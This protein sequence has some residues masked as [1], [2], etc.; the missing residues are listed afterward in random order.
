M[1]KTNVAVIAILLIS[2]AATA[3]VATGPQPFGSFGGGPFDSVNLGSLN[4]NFS[5]PITQ[6]AGRGAPFYYVLSYNSSIW[7]P[8]SVSGTMAWQPTSTSYGWQ[9]QTNAAM[10]GYLS[11][12]AVH[13]RCS[14]SG[15]YWSFSNFVYHDPV[16]GTHLFVGADS[17]LDCDGGSYA[18]S[19]ITEDGTGLT[20]NL[21]TGTSLDG[22]IT[23]RDGSIVN[24]PNVS[25]PSYVDK[26][27]NEITTDGTNFY[28][29]LGA[30][31]LTISGAAPN[32][33]SYTFP[34]SSGGNS[35]VTADYTSFTI[36]TNFGCAGVAEYS[37]AGN[38]LSGMTLPDGTQYQ[39]TYEQTPGQDA[40]HTT[41][42]IAS[43]TLPGTGKIMY[44]YSGGNNGINCSD[45][46]SAGL[47]RALQS[48]PPAT[49]GI[50]T[51]TRSPN[52]AN[53]NTTIT[54]PAGNQS[55]VQFAILNS[56]FYEVQRQVY[57]GSI[58]P[59]S[60]LLGTTHC[61]NGS[62]DYTISAPVT[63]LDVW[64]QP[65]GAPSAKDSE[66]AYNAFGLPTSI[67]E[68]DFDGS[69]NL[70]IAYINYASP[71]NGIVSEPSD[72]TVTDGAGNWV[73]RTV[74]VY[75]ETA[76]TAT[77]GAP[78]H[79]YANYGS[80]FTQRG[81]LTTAKQWVS[82]STYI[83]IASTYDDLGNLRSST[84]A[85]GH[86]TTFDYTDSY[87]DG[88]NHNSQAF[89]TTM[90]Y[91][92]TASGG[93]PTQSHVVKNKYYWPS[94][95]IY[96][97]TDQNNQVTTYT[98]DN[99]WRPSMISYPDG[100]QTSFTHSIFGG[101]MLTET[102]SKIDGTNSTDV[103]HLMDGFGRPSRAAQFN[104]GEVGGGYDQVD[105]CYNSSGQVS[106]V[107]DGYQGPGNAQKICSGAGD[108]FTY[109]ALGRT[110]SVT[111]SD[112]TSVLTT[113]AGR[114]MQVQDE[115]NGSGTHVTHIY[116]Q[117][118]LG[119]TATVC[120]VA[121]T[122]F[123]TGG[124]GACGLDISANPIGVTTSYNYDPLGN[125]T[126]VS[127]GALIARQMSYDGLG[128]LLTEKIPEAGGMTTTYSYNAEGLLQSRTRPSANQAATCIAQGN[129][130]STTTNYAYDELHRLWTTSYADTTS[131]NTPNV[132]MFYDNPYIGGLGGYN[133]GRLTSA[134][135]E[136]KAYST[137]YVGSDIAYDRLGRIAV[138]Q[139]AFHDSPNWRS[140]YVNHS[141]NL[142]GLSATST[143]GVG[144]TFGYTYNR[145]ARLTQLT[146]TLSDANHPGTLF[147]LAHY[148]AGAELVSD[149]LGNGVN[150]TFNYDA[151]WRLLSAH[152][153]SNSTTVY[154]LGGPGTGNV[155]T[156]APNSS[157]T[158]ANDGVNGNRGYSYDALNRIAGANKS[159]GTNLTFDVDRNA[160]R[161]HQNPSGAQVAFDAATNQV[162]SGSGVTYDA[163]GN[164]I[165]DGFHTYTYDAEGRITQVDGGD[166]ATYF[167]DPFGRRARRTVNG[168]AYEDV[169]DGGNMVAE[170]LTSSG[171]WM[172]G[173]VY[174]AGR[175]L[176]TYNNNTTY[177]S[178]TDWS[179]TE[180]VRSA[181]DGSTAGTCTSYP[182]GDNYICTGIDPSPIKYAGMEYD[183]ETQLYHTPHRYYNPRLG[184]WMTPDPAGMAASRTST[185]QSLN[186]YAYVAHNPIN[187]FDPTGLDCA[188]LT[189]D[190]TAV[191]SIDTNSNADEC[192]DNGGYWVNGTVVAGF[193]YADNNNILLIGQL[194]DGT[195]TGA[196][197]LANWNGTVDESLQV[198]F[199]GQFDGAG[200]WHSSWDIAVGF[201]DYVGPGGDY[202]QRD[203]LDWQIR[204]LAIAITW[205]TGRGLIDCSSGVDLLQRVDNGLEWLVPPMPGGIGK[206]L[207]LAQ[208]G[209]GVIFQ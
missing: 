136:D 179:K 194:A 166:T 83:A 183:S 23:R 147:S 108:S 140:Y 71:G 47:S 169:Y 148:N 31:S 142:L 167:Y 27:G 165:N 187:L 100:G 121:S 49:E 46:S 114:A 112:G 176:A 174:L 128:H 12:R 177:F 10:F 135:I 92:A 30:T 62:C 168:T 1:K 209:C 43:V 42:R 99:M 110:T 122:I 203:S 205:Y 106:F 55:V 196:L 107:A 156:Y 88:Q 173:E 19:G 103:F 115:G 130:T 4:V 6:K 144:Y 132:A 87:S 139:E 59:N 94:A 111:H 101:F 57:Q 34:N 113:Y 79:D 60:L 158:G 54:D 133:I 116:Q 191:E 84:D 51:Y 157:L 195:Y 202:W 37:A 93:G 131:E 141:Y 198:S 77:S 138:E 20:L 150:E 98:Y 67:R 185:P 129:C 127:Q 41:G 18:D 45:G 206:G 21:G 73:G 172:R 118:G 159:G 53:W 97:A 8:S 149:S 89:A 16:G 72:V 33:V 161:W 145:A 74:Y 95:M 143:N 56:N 125:V 44:T 66:T 189:D 14:P 69:T 208:K 24:L 160:N 52:G 64:T 58:S 164:I 86:Q 170:M 80:S 162:G 29:T 188:Y 153:T 61:Y 15:F 68:T 36:Q 163:A 76:L 190:G 192:G 13:G 28:D 7:A 137:I 9:S 126:Q 178:H 186:R 152:A 5:I 2:V 117:D 35:V 120:E 109:D 96:Q 180:R 102:Q 22:K 151:R 123:G 17:G 65:T 193:W 182:Y 200:N 48:A 201:I 90:T 81:N 91:P 104:G 175:H 39:F 207:E 40:T 134:Y 181:V 85:G 184:L 75:D 197:D 38:L 124:T 11:H 70:R 154:S 25:T 50:W 82:G 78:N 155:M 105:T 26:N 146:S 32:P 119:R 63:Q 199:D 171:G 3:Q 204:Q